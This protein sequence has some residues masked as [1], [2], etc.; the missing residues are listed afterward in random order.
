MKIITSAQQKGGVGKTTTLVNLAYY[1]NELNTSSKRS[2]K[3][4]LLD[5]DP[6]ENLTNSVS[7]NKDDSLVDASLLFNS[8][9]DIEK[10]PPLE[11]DLEGVDIIRAGS[12]LYDIESMDFSV[13]SNPS[14]HLK[15]LSSIYDY[16]LID[17]PPSLGRL[18]LSALCLADFVYS[19]IKMDDYS[20]SGLEDFIGTINSVKDKLN[21][22]LEFI[23]IVPNL[24]DLKDKSQVKTLKEAQDA[25][26]DVIFK[27]H[28]KHSSTI[29]TAI[30]EKK[31]IWD[32]PKNGNT[33]KMARQV[34]DVAK[35]IISR[36][37]LS[38]KAGDS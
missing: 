29:P 14:K 30:R 31:A 36:C 35:E 22:E 5:L 24:I 34:K 37:V 26:G 2:K 20:L 19:P 21:S 15:K 32:K 1:L 7:S 33:A 8:E 38:E 17:T 11:T 18:S 16:I 6:Q 4:L 9:F 27:N 3:I 25:W 10:T 23:G 28:I 13:I 12:L